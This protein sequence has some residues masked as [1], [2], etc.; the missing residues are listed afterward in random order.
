MA[1]RVLAQLAFGH[2]VVAHCACDGGVGAIRLHVSAKEGTSQGN[3]A[4]LC[5]VCA[6][7]DERVCL[8][9]QGGVVGQAGGGEWLAALRG[10]VLVVGHL[11]ENQMWV[12]WG[13][14]TAPMVWC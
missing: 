11:H 10:H 12:S 9:L 7:N 1:G 2:R 14:G 6:E 13:S 4:A 5:A 8:S 3:I